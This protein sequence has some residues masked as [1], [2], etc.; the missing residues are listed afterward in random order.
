MNWITYHDD[1]FGDWEGMDDPDA[2]TFYH[3]VQATNV[4]KEC[5][6]CG[7]LV[8]IQ[9]HYAYCNRCATAIERGA[10]FYALPGP[11]RWVSSPTSGALF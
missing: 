9:P 6:G 10:A 1:N 3:Q 2:Q 7:N 11:G 8:K 4:E 5:Q